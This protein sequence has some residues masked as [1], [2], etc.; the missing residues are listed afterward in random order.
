[1][2]E[3]IPETRIEPRDAARQRMLFVVDPRNTDRKG[4]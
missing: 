1:M 2:S 4:I 3:E